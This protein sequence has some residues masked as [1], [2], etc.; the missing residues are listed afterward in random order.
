MAKIN[1]KNFLAFSFV[2]IL[3]LPLVIIQPV[4]GE[5]NG[6]ISYSINSD[7]TITPATV[8]I[9]SIGNTYT[10]TGDIRGSVTVERSDIILD[11]NGH[12]IIGGGDEIGIGGLTIGSLPTAPTAGIS[13]ISNV[14]VKNFKITGS[15]MGISLWQASNV[16]VTNNSISETGNGILS[17]D[18]QTAAIMVEGGGSN[19][20]TANHIANNYNGIICFETINNLITKNYIAKNSNSAIGGG[21]GIS[22]WEASNNTIYHNDFIDNAVQAYDGITIYASGELPRAS[23]VWDDGFPDGG[24][25]WSDYLTKYPH[26][27]MI[28]DSGL[29]NVSYVI[30]GKNMDRY[31]LLEPFIDFYTIATTPPRITTISVENRT[32]NESAVPAFFSIDKTANWTGYSLDGEQNITVTGNFTVANMTSGMHNISIYANDTFGNMGVQTVN[33]TVELPTPT[34]TNLPIVPQT[35]PI[36]AIVAVLAIIVVS[37]LLFKRHRKTQNNLVKKV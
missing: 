29:G 20:I 36:I 31:P 6:Y 11:G 30:D 4:V 17:L 13:Y 26:A 21:T 15:V 12:S 25:Y 19:T 5:Y 35:L 3:V 23:N 16:I 9:Q 8:P 7:G 24:N 18:Q 1:L 32:F 33:F 34:P 28:D 37:L 22:I 10:L 27:Q 2:F 14:T